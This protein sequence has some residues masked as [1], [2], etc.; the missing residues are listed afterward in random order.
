[1]TINEDVSRVELK[2]ESGT[3]Y[4]EAWEI[5][6]QKIMTPEEYQE[7]SIE[8]IKAENALLDEAVVELATMLGGE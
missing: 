3:A 4:A 8:Q 5:G 2:D 1:M 6:T 7:Y